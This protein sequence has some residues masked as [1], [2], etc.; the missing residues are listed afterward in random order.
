MPRTGWTGI[1]VGNVHRIVIKPYPGGESSANA[2][3]LHP[4]DKASQALF[5][6]RGSCPP[7][8][9]GPVLEVWVPGQDTHRE[10][11]LIV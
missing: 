10:L 7:P 3:V 5:A 8:E 4:S 11:E 6:G 2:W 9:S 1:V